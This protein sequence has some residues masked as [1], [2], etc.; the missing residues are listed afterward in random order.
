LHIGDVTPR[1][2]QHALNEWIL[3]TLRYNLEVGLSERIARRWLCKLGWR[4]TRLKK[5][6][7]MDGHERG[8]VKEYRQ[9]DFLPK[10]ASFERRMAKWEPRSSRLECTAPDLRPGKKRVIAIF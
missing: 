3:L 7:Y 8:D 4:Q 6:I 1:Q 5:G 9:N 2:F 10:M